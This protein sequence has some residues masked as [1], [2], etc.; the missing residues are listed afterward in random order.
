MIFAIGIT[1]LQVYICISFINF[2]KS[3]REIMDRI[4]FDKTIATCGL[5]KNEDYN[6]IE[7][8][9]IFQY[10]LKDSRLRRSSKKLPVTLI[11]CKVITILLSF[12]NFTALPIF[13]I[14]TTLIWLVISYFYYRDFPHLNP[15][16]NVIPFASSVSI[17]F[18]NARTII[19]LMGSSGEDDSYAVLSSFLLYMS[20]IVFVA[21]FFLAQRKADTL[22]SDESDYYN[23]IA[24][25]SNKDTQ[26]SKKLRQVIQEKIKQL[27]MK[28]VRINV[29]RIETMWKKKNIAQND[30]V[31]HAIFSVENGVGL[32][33]LMVLMGKLW[34]EQ[35]IYFSK[36]SVFNIDFYVDGL[37]VVPTFA[38]SVI[39]FTFM[40]E[41]CKYM[42]HFEMHN[43]VFY[44]DDFLAHMKIMSQNPKLR[45]VYVFHN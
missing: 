29:A 37:N 15:A 13:P 18:S 28:G 30:I 36:L 41:L 45:F 5:K 24:T 6:N 21:A 39:H 12:K 38:S 20:P 32:I 40:S 2:F 3:S 4:N 23:I 10:I 35:N 34:R 17:T 1:I 25:D 8:R 9:S 11:Y 27:N 14:I 16:S 42:S 31:G 43:F 33:N 7:H 44:R 19:A 26:G 22:D